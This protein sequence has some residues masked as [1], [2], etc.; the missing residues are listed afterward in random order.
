MPKNMHVDHILA[1]NHSE[2]KDADFDAY[3]AEL[4]DAGFVYD[5]LE[6][7]LPTCAS[8]NLTKNSKNFTTANLRFFHQKALDHLDKTLG[9]YELA[10]T[11]KAD[12]PCVG[13]SS[14]CWER[15]DFSYQRDISYAISQYRLGAADVCACPRFEQVEEVK[16]CLHR[17]DY[18]TVQGNP[19][20]G[21]S[22]TIFQAAFDYFKDGWTVFRLINNK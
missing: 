8:C 13:E 9:Q 10:K 19:G 11:K 3:Y 1:S 15:I 21:K 16:N 17:V 22:I 5:S 12:F 7:Y 2:T 18:V 20:C 14:D 4:M 6:N